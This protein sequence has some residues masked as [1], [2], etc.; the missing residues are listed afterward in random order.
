MIFGDRDAL[1]FVTANPH[2][3]KNNLLFNFCMLSLRIETTDGMDAPQVI[4]A[5]RRNQD[6]GRL[7]LKRN[8]RECVRVFDHLWLRESRLP[9]ADVIRLLVSSMLK[10]RHL[11]NRRRSIRMS[12]HYF[13]V[14]MLEQYCA[15][16]AQHETCLRAIESV[17]VE[18]RWPL[19]MIYSAVKF[20]HVRKIVSLE[21]LRAWCRESDNVSRDLRHYIDNID[22]SSTDS[23]GLDVLYNDA[24]EQ[25]GIDVRTT[26]QRMLR[27][28]PKRLK[29]SIVD[30]MKKREVVVIPPLTLSPAD[31]A[32]QGTATVLEWC[33]EKTRGEKSPTAMIETFDRYRRVLMIIKWHV[34]FAGVSCICSL[35]EWCKSRDM[36]CVE[37]L[38]YFQ[39]H[40][41]IL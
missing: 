40:R 39:A 20:L 19:S 34:G 11:P 15:R 23:F 16:K 14:E 5:I 13:Y 28:Y 3:A 31:A 30:V 26:Y 17:V 9:I 41:I 12:D 38:D 35:V 36:N 24:T 22:E 6:D 37:L 1:F 7:R 25:F 8:T 32:W 4:R 29:Q 2:N 27:S 10:E 18:R 21:S 33:Y